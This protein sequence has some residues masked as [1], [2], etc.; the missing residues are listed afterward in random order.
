MNI[1]SI[2]IRGGKK[3][4]KRVWVRDMCFKHGIQFLGVQETK[5][6]KLEPFRIKCMWG[7]FCFEY[8]CSLSRGRSGGI[9]SIWD[10]NVLTKDQ[11]WCSDNFVIMKG[12]WSGHS[13]DYFLVNI[14]SP[15][16]PIA[17]IHLWVQ[18]LEF[19]SQ[20][21]GIYIFFGD[22]NEVRSE[23]DRYGTLFNV[24]GATAFNT[25]ISDAGLH[26]LP[27]GGRRYSWM[28]KSGSKMSLLDRFLVSSEEDF[29]PI[30][31]KFF[32]S[33]MTRDGFKELVERVWN[34]ECENDRLVVKLR[35][36]KMEIKNWI[37]E[38]R[39]DEKGRINAIKLR[40][41]EIEGKMDRSCASL[42]ELDERTRIFGE[43]NDCID[44]E[45]MDVIQ[46]ARVKWDIEG[47]ENS[48][49]FHAMINHKRSE[50]AIKG[51]ILNGE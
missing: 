46:K 24:H 38:V 16:D 35:K 9:L 18:L 25:F 48:G 13:G 15:Q 11:I 12:T 5:M 30:P 34:T 3:R 47:D 45:E 43:L 21:D 33:W 40:I 49:F 32:N 23:E 7:N 39:D 14:Y 37:G 26:D 42:E 20:N 41:D 2:N 51:V 22:F 1:L 44:R 50:G 17:K 36:L 6:E 19:K 10:P 27:L 29:G 28:N 4:R 8:A 31:F